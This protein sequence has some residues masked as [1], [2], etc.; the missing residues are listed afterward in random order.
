MKDASSSSALPLLADM[1]AIMQ[2]TAAA[3]PQLLDDTHTII[4]LAIRPFRHVFITY[5][6][7]HNA[8]NWRGEG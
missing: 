3:Q 4:W 6:Q 7:I 5:I 1:Y 8:Y 2:L